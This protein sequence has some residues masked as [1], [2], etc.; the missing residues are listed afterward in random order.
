MTEDCTFRLLSEAAAEFP[1]A[2]HGIGSLAT[3][4]GRAVDS[5]GKLAMITSSDSSEVP[6]DSSYSKQ[7]RQII[8]SCQWIRNN[9]DKI[10][11][12]C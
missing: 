4:W 5:S 6:S 3:S 10:I 11:N 8:N 12:S 2:V 9:T 7:Y 1:V